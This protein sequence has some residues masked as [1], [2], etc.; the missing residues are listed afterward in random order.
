MRARSV[1]IFG[2]RTYTTL[3]GGLSGKSK[4]RLQQIIDWVGGE[5]F[6]GCIVRPIQPLAPDMSA[7][8]TL[9]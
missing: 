3:I 6:D 1:M 8:Y 7:H 9:I 5:S 4:S 2:C